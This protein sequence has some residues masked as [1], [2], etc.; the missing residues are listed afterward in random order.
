MSRM[1]VFGICSMAVFHLLLWIV[2]IT[3][4]QSVGGDDDYDDLDDNGNSQARTFKKV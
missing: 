3:I 1:T 4:F 2:A